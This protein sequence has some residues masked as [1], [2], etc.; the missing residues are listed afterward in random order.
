MLPCRNRN[1]AYNVA[2]LNKKLV[3]PNFEDRAA[4]SLFFSIDTSTPL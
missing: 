1:A 2:I 3:N 4:F